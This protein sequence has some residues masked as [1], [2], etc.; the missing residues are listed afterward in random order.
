MAE[1]GQLLRHA[2]ERTTAIYAKVDQARLCGV[3]DPQEIAGGCR[4]CTPSSASPHTVTVSSPRSSIAR[5]RL[6]RPDASNALKDLPILP[7]GIEL[8]SISWLKLMNV[9]ATKSLELDTVTTVV[10]CS[11][12][13]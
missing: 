11:L 3:H 1:I 7:C 10:I 13:R 8:D 2:Q 9:L 5:H 6:D 4:A 12:N